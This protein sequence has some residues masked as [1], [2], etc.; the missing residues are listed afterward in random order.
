MQ[1]L[2]LALIKMG[3]S[4]EANLIEGKWKDLLVVSGAKIEPEYSRCFPPHILKQIVESAFEGFSGMECRIAQKSTNDP[5]YTVLN[6]AWR[7]FW[8]HPAGYAAWEKQAR[9]HL[10]NLC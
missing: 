2:L 1:V 8:S 3:F 5:V 9:E 7:E 10:R 6:Q 4:R